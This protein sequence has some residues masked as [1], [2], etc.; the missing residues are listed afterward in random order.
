MRLMDDT[1]P[2]ANPKSKIYLVSN[3]LADITDWVVEFS[4]NVEE[5]RTMLEN[6][7]S[8][9]RW[10]GTGETREHKNK[11]IERKPLSKVQRRAKR[12]KCPTTRW[13]NKSETWLCERQAFVVASNS[14]TLLQMQQ[15]GTAWLK[16]AQHLV[17]FFFLTF[18]PIRAINFLTHAC[19]SNIS[20]PL[21][22]QEDN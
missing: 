6:L 2:K 15:A 20:L 7:D 12:R 11:R 3:F 8:M 22:S 4:T 16:F 18:N 5:T 19:S 13:T 9:A 10:R 21:L 14:Q 17:T 1:C